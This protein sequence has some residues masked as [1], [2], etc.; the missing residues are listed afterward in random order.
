M[1]TAENYLLLLLSAWPLSLWRKGYF[2]LQKAY[3]CLTINLRI[4]LVDTPL[5]RLDS[6][7]SF[8]K[9]PITNTAQYCWHKHCPINVC[10]CKVYAHVYAGAHPYGR[11]SGCRS[12]FSIFL[13][14]IGLRQ[15]LN[16]LKTCSYSGLAVPFALR[17]SLS[18]CLGPFLSAGSRH[19]QLRL[20]N[21]WLL[22]IGTQVS[23]L[24]EQTLWPI[25]PPPCPL[26]LCSF[27][28]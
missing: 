26:I 27:L 2:V 1:V 18:P 10:V 12:F 5:N 16:N 22:G 14:L 11:Q 13:S 20:A 21:T 6:L 25:E 3:K 19:I 24:T 4:Q 17:L 23:M 15:G 8:V 9:Y 7:F 28:I